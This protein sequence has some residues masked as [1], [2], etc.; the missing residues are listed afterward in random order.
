MEISIRSNVGKKRKTNQDYADYFVSSQGHYLFVLCDGVGGHLSGDVASELTTKYMGQ[1]FLEKQATLNEEDI[2]QWIKDVVEDVNSYIYQKSLE[3]DRLGGMGTTLIFAL[4]LDNSIFI[5]HVGDSRAY[6]FQNNQLIQLTED[7]SLVNELIRIG[8]ITKEEGIDH[9]SRNIVTE[10][11]GITPTVS[12]EMAKLSRNDISQLML[13][14]DGLTN[15]LP[16]EEMNQMF[17][18]QSRID[19]LSDSLINAANDAGGKDN[20][21]IVLVANIQE[22]EREEGELSD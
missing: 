12:F 21:T 17:R 22:I 7:Q 6:A 3:D 8:E 2:V 4:V 14:S 1:R 18:D 5:T 10:S 16:L 15:M 13:C 9:P 20:I 19:Q 11:I